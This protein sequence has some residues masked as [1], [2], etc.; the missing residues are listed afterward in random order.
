MIEIK[1]LSFGFP[2]KELFNNVSFTIEDGQHAAFIGV[3]GGGKTTLIEMIMDDEKFM[4]DGKILIDPS[5]RIGHVSQFY[6]KPVADTHTVFEYLCEPFITL[7][8]EIDAL[9]SLMETAEDLEPILE[10]YQTAL[11][12]FDAIGGHDYET[13]ILKKLNLAS[14]GKLKDL[15]IEQISGG[16]FKLVQ[17]IKEM[18]SNPHL[19]IMDEPDV[20]L[21]FENL[22]A[23]KDLINAHKGMLFVVTH[24]R[25]LLN[26]C[27]NKIIHLENMEVQE[28]EGNFIQYKF[29]L[30]ENKIEQQELSVKD[31]EE[32]A[33]NEALIGKLRIIATNHSEASRGRALKARVKVQE[34]LEARRI[35]APFVAIKQPNI[36][37]EMPEIGFDSEDPI[38]S[39]ENLNLRFEHDLIK[40]ANFEINAGEKVALIGANGTGKTTL[41]REIRRNQNDCVKIADDIKIGYLS[42]SVHE[43]IDES[44]TVLDTF[45]EIGMPTSES[46][47]LHVMHFGFESDVLKQKISA[48]SGGEKNLMQLAILTAQKNDLLLLDEP[49]SHLDTYAQMAL[50][51]AIEGYKG[52]VLMISHD[53]Y[54]IANCM[55][56]VLIIEDHT[57][58]KMSIRKFRKMIYENHFKHSYLELEQ[59]K[60]ALETKIETALSQQEFESAKLWATELEEIINQM[61]A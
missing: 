5:C 46:I 27:F 18:V 56:H 28:F 55:D 11:D 54:M 16:E 38:L 59:K 34:R 39:V 57:V 10:K 31:D 8:T 60:K 58:R 22:S 50:E 26:H 4:Y 35:K 32:I 9:C 25:Y 20:F 45:Y 2:Q 37:F 61:I 19:L 52:T 51:S 44:Q 49:T 47:R 3:S 6:K 12:A 40:Q 21:D 48:L 23:L 7:Q 43:S 24:N 30:L 33:R 1:D 14:L 53:Y 13:D 36:K 15:S 42:Q 17:V 41:F 29:E